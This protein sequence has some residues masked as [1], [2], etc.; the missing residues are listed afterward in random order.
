M[1][2]QDPATRREIEATLTRAFA[3]HKVEVLWDSGDLL[4]RVT[5]DEMDYSEE[6]SGAGLTWSR[7]M[8]NIATRRRDFLRNGVQFDPWDPPPVPPTQS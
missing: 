4:Y 6:I 7:A 5:V 2:V 1:P 3:P 8:E